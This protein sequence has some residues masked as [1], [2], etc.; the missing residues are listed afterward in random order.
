M[1]QWRRVNFCG[2]IVSLGRKSLGHL[3]WIIVDIT[4]ITKMKFHY[5]SNQLMSIY[6]QLFVLLKIKLFIIEWKHT[7]LIKWI[8][9]GFRI[10]FSA[11]LFQRYAE[12]HSI[13][14]QL[15]QKAYI[16]KIGA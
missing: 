6:F 3:S 7:P 15:Q 16:F 2:R 4:I 11:K 8:N 1:A 9:Y 14:I 12:R 5:Y 13:S 10:C